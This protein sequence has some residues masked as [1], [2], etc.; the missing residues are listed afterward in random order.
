MSAMKF[1]FFVLYI[2]IYMY[3]YICVCPYRR[4][5]SESLYRMSYLGFQLLT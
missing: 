3:I 2:Y 1:P 4:A 5:C